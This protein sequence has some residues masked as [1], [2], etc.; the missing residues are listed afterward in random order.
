MG[1]A[2]GVFNLEGAFVESPETQR[3]EV[4]IPLAVIDLGE[5]HD[6]LAQCL[7]DIYPL[8]VPADAGVATHATHLI[9]EAGMASSRASCGR[10]VLYSTRQ[11]SRRRCCA[12]GV[13]SGGRVHSRLR[14]R[15][16]RSWPACCWGEAGVMRSG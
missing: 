15:C 13:R 3:P 7:T 8:L 12:W 10:T 16:I 9:M 5:A 4:E 2:Q 14:V 1:P 6:P 11:V